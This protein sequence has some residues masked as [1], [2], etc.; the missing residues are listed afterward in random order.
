MRECSR[1]EETS[2]YSNRE[3]VH[4]EDEGS[5]DSEVLVDGILH[6]ANGMN[7]ELCNVGVKLIG[8]SDMQSIPRTEGSR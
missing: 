5:I 8:A 2:T 3:L 1:E 7:E 6:I 4:D